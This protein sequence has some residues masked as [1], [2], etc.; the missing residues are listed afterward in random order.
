MA[1]NERCKTAEET[2]ERETKNMDELSKAVKEK[3]SEV[4]IT[5]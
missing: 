1:A 5:I 4:S 2:I 3:F